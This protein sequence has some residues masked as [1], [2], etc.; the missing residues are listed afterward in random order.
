MGTEVRIFIVLALILGLCTSLPASDWVDQGDGTW[1]LSVTYTAAT[2]ADKELYEKCREWDNSR[3]RYAEDVVSAS[4]W[5]QGILQ[6]LS[7]TQEDVPQYPG[8]AK[9]YLRG[10]INKFIDYWVPASIEDKDT[11]ARFIEVPAPPSQP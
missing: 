11:A 5:F 3:Y 6:G 4:E 7:V 9:N 8:N 2:T 1:Q 10:L